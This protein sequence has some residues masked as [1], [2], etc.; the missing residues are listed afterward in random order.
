MG[1][2]I[3]GGMNTMW[4]IVMF[5]L[6]TVTPEERHDYA[7]FRKHLLDDGFMMMQYSVYMRHCA[8]DENASVHS[9][10][11]KNWLPP[12]GEVR[13]MRLTDKQ[14]GKI[15]IFYGKITF[16]IEKPPQQLLLF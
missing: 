4:L 12:N 1:N 8:S 5:D 3:F 14:F 15:E 7:H 13:M 10:R 16:E 2:I 6:P 11:V 9:Q